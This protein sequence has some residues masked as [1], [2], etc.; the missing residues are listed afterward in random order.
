MKEEEDLLRKDKQSYLREVKR[1]KHGLPHGQQM[2]MSNYD[3]DAGL[4]QLSLSSLTT[5]QT[6]SKTM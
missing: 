2:Q 4:D 1:L 5:Q 6:K 3:V